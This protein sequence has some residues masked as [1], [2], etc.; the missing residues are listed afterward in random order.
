MIKNV[1]SQCST[2]IILKITNPADLKAVISGSEG[3][4]KSSEFEIQKLN[5]GTAL[6]CGIVDI[7]LKINI[8]PRITKHG[9]ETTDIV[10]DYENDDK[11]LK[12]KKHNP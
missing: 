2:Q 5:I 10:L 4:N 7:P 1:I 8:R 12:E 3:L 6:L 11:L 9:G